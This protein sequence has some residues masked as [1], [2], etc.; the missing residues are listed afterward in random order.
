MMMI[1]KEQE[2]VFSFLIWSYRTG[3]TKVFILT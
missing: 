3:G 1:L 2:N